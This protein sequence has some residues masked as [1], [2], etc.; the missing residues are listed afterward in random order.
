MSSASA[1][2][3]SGTKQT[4]E[5]YSVPMTCQARQLKSPL[6]QNKLTEAIFTTDMLSASDEIRCGSKQAF[7][8]K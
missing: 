3:R 5:K 2:I 4:L 6:D 7:E 8:K 1:E